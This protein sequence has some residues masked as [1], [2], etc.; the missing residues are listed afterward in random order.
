MVRGRESEIGDTRTAPNGYH[1]TKTEDGWRL[2]HHILA[3]EA[4]GRPLRENE[5][6][7]FRDGDRTNLS[8]DNVQV[9]ETRDRKQDRADELR[10]KIR[11]YRRELKELEQQGY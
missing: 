6:V 5:R 10:A 4:L 1:Y 11:V 3:E 7:Y 9:R 8:K 2:T